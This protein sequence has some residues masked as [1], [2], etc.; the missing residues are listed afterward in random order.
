MRTPAALDII[1]SMSDVGDFLVGAGTVLNPDQ[2]D[3]VV[4]AGARFIVSPG[5]SADVVRRSQELGVVVVPG[6]A[7]ASEI[8][9]AHNLGL[10]TVKFFPA[11]VAGGPAAIKALGGPFRDIDFIPTG[12]VNLRYTCAALPTCATLA[13]RHVS[14]ALDCRSTTSRRGT[15]YAMRRPLRPAIQC[16]GLPHTA[17]SASPTCPY[18]HPLR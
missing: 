2:V 16:R 1:R 5:L 11:N 6:V 8:M 12:G 17:Q 3:A 9:H 15:L 4:A 10:R 7:T 18:G 13:R 14:R